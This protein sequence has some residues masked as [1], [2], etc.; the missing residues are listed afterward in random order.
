MDDR[1]GRSRWISTHYYE[2]NVKMIVYSIPSTMPGKVTRISGN[3]LYI[4]KRWRFTFL[5]RVVLF[6]N[7]QLFVYHEFFASEFLKEDKGKI[8]QHF[9]SFQMV[10]KCWE[11]WS[12]FI[13]IFKVLLFTGKIIVS[14]ISELKLF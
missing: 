3:R 6:L 12:K 7:G 1:Y 9:F 11:I 2:F 4:Q 14:V 8:Y 10:L 5:Q 13:P